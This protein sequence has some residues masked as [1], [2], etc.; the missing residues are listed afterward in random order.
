MTHIK[1]STWNTAQ[2][3]TINSKNSSFHQDFEKERRLL[4]DQIW[5]APVWTKK[6]GFWWQLQCVAAAYYCLSIGKAGQ[7]GI[8]Q[9]HGKQCR[10]MYSRSHTRRSDIKSLSS[11]EFSVSSM[12][13]TYI[14]PRRVN[15]S[16]EGAPMEKASSI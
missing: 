15:I 13:M 4:S 3:Y 2:E 11:Q 1:Q 5:T 8:S 7:R 12:L 14:D 6:D 10:V 16:V 9:L